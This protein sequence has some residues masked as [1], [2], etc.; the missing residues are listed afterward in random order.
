[1]NKNR[2][3]KLVPQN[4]R[5]LIDDTF[6]K[7]LR[8]QI[9][10]IMGGGLEEFADESNC[11]NCESAGWMA[12]FWKACEVTGK[13]KIFN[14]WK[15][16]PGFEDGSFPADTFLGEVE[17]QLYERGYILPHKAEL[18]KEKLGIDRNE[19]VTCWHCGHILPVDMAL[20]EEEIGEEDKYYIC[21]YCQDVKNMGE[22]PDAHCSATDYY[23]ECLKGLN[24]ATKKK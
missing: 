1:M 24:E 18:I 22:D 21:S 13:M 15:S 19:T 5:D 7:E 20:V 16:L 11:L 17:Y 2:F 8:N 23:R 10:R 14:Y 3:E 12:A 4:I 9:F 6:L